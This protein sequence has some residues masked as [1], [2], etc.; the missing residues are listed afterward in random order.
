MGSSASREGIS[1]RVQ[2]ASRSELVDI[3]QD[4]S[5]EVKEQ[6]FSEYHRQLL[7][8]ALEFKG[9]EEENDMDQA[10]GSARGTSKAPKSHEANFQLGQIT[11]Q[12]LGE[13][14]T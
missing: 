11:V 8:K 4:L 7:V 1:R 13:F 9:S 10:H 3:V 2:N 12:P 6:D 14:A 5:E